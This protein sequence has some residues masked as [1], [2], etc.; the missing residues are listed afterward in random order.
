MSVIKK[1]NLREK[2]LGWDGVNFRRKGWQGFCAEVGCWKTDG[3]AVEPAL[4]LLADDPRL[5]L[6]DTTRFLRPLRQGERDP[7]PGTL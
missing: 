1:M 3:L 6:S 7:V 2:L 4:F 5:T